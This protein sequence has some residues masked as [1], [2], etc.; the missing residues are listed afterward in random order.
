[1]GEVHQT[2]DTTTDRVDAPRALPPHLAEDETFQRRFRREPQVAAGVNDRM[3]CRSTATSVCGHATQRRAAP[4]TGAMRVLSQRHLSAP[5]R[6]AAKRRRDVVV[7]AGGEAADSYSHHVHHFGESHARDI[8]FHVV[9]RTD[10]SCSSQFR[11]PMPA[12]SRYSTT[13][14]SRSRTAPRCARPLV[15]LRTSLARQRLSRRQRIAGYSP[16]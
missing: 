12:R 14:A 11:Q 8:P 6:R 9:A 5:R 4:N 3:W 15:A 10:P 7:R 16:R 1:M 2:C 13:R